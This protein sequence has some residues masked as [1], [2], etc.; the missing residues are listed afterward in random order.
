MPKKVTDVDGI[1]KRIEMS[2]NPLSADVFF[3]QGSEYTYIVDVGSND[4]SYEAI[5][6]IPKKK[7]IITHFHA[8]HAE[9]LRRLNVPDED[10]YVGDYTAKYYGGGTVIKEPMHLTDGVVIDILPLPSSHAKGSLTAIVNEDTILLGD[11]CYSNNKGYNVSLL[12]DLI[13]VLKAAEFKK[14][15]KSH[16]PDTYTKEELIN[17][18]E[19]IYSFKEKRNPYISLDKLKGV[20]V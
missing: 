4:A 12:H 6:A 1:I 15:V 14:A 20:S 7:V 9:N 3:I 11:G 17:E 2:E 19:T 18:L 13:K 10:L 8:D 16:E 5:K